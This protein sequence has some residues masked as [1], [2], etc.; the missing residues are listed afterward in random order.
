[1]NRTPCMLL[2]FFMFAL[3][4]IGL[5]AP[6]G[7]IGDPMLWN[8]GPFQK[9]GGFS[10]ITTLVCERQTNHLPEQVTRFGWTNP[11]S[12]PLEQR[13][14]PQTRL[15]KNT[16]D[17]LGLKVGVPVRDRAVVYAVV[18]V[19]EATIDLHYEDWTVSRSFASND[20]FESGPDV[21]YGLGASIVLQ[22][23][24][25]KKIPWTAGMDLSWRRYSIEE[26]KFQTEGLSYSSTLDE[27]Q[28]AFSVSA[29]IERF[30]PYFGVK[31][32]SI[33]G[34]EDYINKNYTT[35]YFE[36]KYIHYTEDITWSKNIGYF[37]GVTTAIKGLMTVGLEI[38]GGDENA[39][40]I[41]ATT[42]F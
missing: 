39:L 23:G 9:Q 14:Y 28:L 6:V 34:T 26:D 17:I 24:E 22:R 30:S 1:M 19:S 37:M 41:N 32:A 3:P 13:H 21:Y 40:S 4:A 2:I 38:R 15:S 16:L 27:I 42:R 29:E 35:Y 8:P 7:N 36:E 25:Y 5:A 20:T 11:N 31:V 18:G 12:S 33:T 10:F